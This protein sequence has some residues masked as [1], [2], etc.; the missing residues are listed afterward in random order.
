MFG[1]GIWEMVILGVIGLIGL[2]TVGG[3]IAAIVIASSSSH[4]Q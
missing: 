4:R 3:I 1:I 2:G